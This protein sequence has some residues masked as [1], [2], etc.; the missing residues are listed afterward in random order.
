MGSNG[1]EQLAP[2]PVSDGAHALGH[3]DPDAADLWPGDLSDL[4]G[5]RGPPIPGIA[6]SNARHGLDQHRPYGDGLPG[7]SGLGAFRLERHNEQYMNTGS[8]VTGSCRKGSMNVQGTC[9]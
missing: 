3:P 6:G 7:S 9:N 5:R 4:T 2:G 1:M 8:G